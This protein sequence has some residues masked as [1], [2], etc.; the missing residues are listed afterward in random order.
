MNKIQS[1]VLLSLSLAVLAACTIAVILALPFLA[2][3]DV[4]LVVTPTPTVLSFMGHGDDFVTF[5]NPIPGLALFFIKHTGD[6]FFAATL[7][8]SDGRLQALLANSI[9]AYEGETTEH[10]ER[11]QY[12]L[13]IKADGPWLVVV[14]L[15][16]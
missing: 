4:P 13:G 10:M 11:G 15:P 3:R 7:K 9:G 16:K 14:G 12:I 1:L 5:D 8:D 6:H 2:P